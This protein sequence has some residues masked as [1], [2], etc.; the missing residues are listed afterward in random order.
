MDFPDSYT[1]QNSRDALTASYSKVARRHRHRH[2]S[3]TF[4]EIKGQISE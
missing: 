4:G 2:I 3:L 1:F